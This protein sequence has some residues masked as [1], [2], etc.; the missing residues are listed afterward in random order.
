MAQLAQEKDREEQK[1]KSGGGFFGFLKKALPFAAMAIPFVGP[2]IGMSALGAGALST[3]L[4]VGGSLMNKD[5][6][7]AALNAA[8]GGFQGAQRPGLRQP[9]PLQGTQA[10]RPGNAMYGPQ[11]I[12]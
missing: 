11:R 7:G 8:L 1:K 4:G 5:Y 10:I 6:T 9:S 2:A 12:G 3:G